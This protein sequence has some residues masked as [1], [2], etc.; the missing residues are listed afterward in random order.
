MSENALDVSWPEEIL[1][2]SCLLRVFHILQHLVL[3][4]VKKQHRSAERPT[5]FFYAP[6]FML[7]C[8][9]YLPES[10]PR[11]SI[12]RVLMRGVALSHMTWIRVTPVSSLYHFKLNLPK[13][14]DF[15]IWILISKPMTCNFTWTWG[16]WLGMTQ[17]PPW[18]QRSVQWLKD[19]FES[20]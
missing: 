8:L 10:A 20:I 17:N 2:C 13:S 6:F 15:D 18:A 7:Y 4:R 9:S 19:Y 14:R 16:F 11:H 5:L 3:T 1:Y 12:W